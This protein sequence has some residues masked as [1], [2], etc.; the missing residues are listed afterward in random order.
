MY[1]DLRGS[2]IPAMSPGHYSSTA[3][4]PP[5][6]ACSDSCIPPATTAT[7][8]V[9]RQSPGE[10]SSPSTVILLPVRKLDI[11]VWGGGGGGGGG[12]MGDPR[13]FRRLVLCL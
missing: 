5:G 13:V 7:T 12:G 1:H 8:A 3:A 9:T 6:P 4:I 10:L 2:T 11:F